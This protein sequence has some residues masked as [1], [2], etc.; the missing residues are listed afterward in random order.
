MGLFSSIGNIA[1]TVANYTPGG[2]IYGAA[3]GTGAFAKNQSGPQA[4]D[5]MADARTR[6]IDA[7]QAQSDKIQANAA[8]FEK[9]LPG[10]R[11]RMIGAAGDVERKG[12]NENIQ[13]VRKGAS[14]RGLLYSG[15]RQGAEAGAVGQANSNIAN[16]TTAINEDLARRQAELQDAAATSG[17]NVLGAKAGIAGQNFSSAMDKSAQRSKGLSSLMSGVGSVGGSALGGMGGGQQ[18]QQGQQMQGQQ[19]AAQP[20]SDLYKNYKGYA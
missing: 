19:M 20:N 16:K 7:L 9:D 4:P 12:A 1:K 13:A 15:L 8:Q 2:L 5:A 14:R 18:Q 10:M 11:S 6:Y 17:L 3:T